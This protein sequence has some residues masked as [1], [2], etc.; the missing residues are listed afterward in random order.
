MLPLH[1]FFVVWA[2]LALNVLTPGPNVINTIATAMSAGRAPGVGAA[3]GV[4]VGVG[5][6]CL[7]TTLGIA[8]LFKLVPGL[9]HNLS[10]VAI[11]LLAWFALRYLRVAWAGWRG[12][13]KGLPS[14]PRQDSFGSAFW[15]SLMI[16]WLNPKALTTWLAILT[17]F[18]VARAGLSDVVLLWVGAVTVAGSMHIGYA[19]V[20]STKPAARFYLRYGWVMSGV[21]GVLFSLFALRLLLE[22]LAE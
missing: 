17:I 4:G 20:F 14:L 18:P 5:G 6:W 10:F 15:R 16:N 13:R 21:A 7:A 3:F 22:L 12:A 11:G 19:L 9:Q 8:A 2:I 1:E